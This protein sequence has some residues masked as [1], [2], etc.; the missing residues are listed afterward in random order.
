MPIDAE[1]DGLRLAGYAALPTYSRGAAVPQYLF[2]N[3]RPVRD[4]LLT[5]RAARR[6]CATSCRA[7]GTRRPRS[8]STAT[9]SGST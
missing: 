2:V 5:R 3:G 1:R 8:S 6:L 4:K 9:R 7:T